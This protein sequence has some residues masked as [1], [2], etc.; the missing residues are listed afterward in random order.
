MHA[1][2]C[3]DLVIGY[4]LH[5]LACYRPYATCNGLNRYIC[6]LHCIDTI[7]KLFLKHISLILKES[8]NN[9][10]HGNSL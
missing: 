4:M 10:D 3:I 7:K 1:T 2:F 6:M 9:L 8:F 5:A